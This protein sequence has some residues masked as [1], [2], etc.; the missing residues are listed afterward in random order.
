[1]KNSQVDE[2]ILQRRALILSE[3]LQTYYDQIKGKTIVAHF[4][5]SAIKEMLVTGNAESIYYTRDDKSAFI[6]VNKT[7]CSRMF[8]TFNSGEIHLLKYYGDNTSNLLPMGEANHNTL[9]LEGFNWRNEERPYDIND[10]Y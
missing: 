6:G 4:D 8:F 9:R 2:I 3:I 7:I 5:S 1:M 10:L